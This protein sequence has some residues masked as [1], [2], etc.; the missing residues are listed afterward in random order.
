MSWGKIIDGVTFN[1]FSYGVPYNTQHGN[2]VGL[3]YQTVNGVWES[4]RQVK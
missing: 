1:F 4:V 3:I 2:Q